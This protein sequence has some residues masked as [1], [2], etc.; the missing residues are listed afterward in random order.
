MTDLRE[1]D[2]IEF[3]TCPRC[4]LSFQ[5]CGGFPK[6]LYIPASKMLKTLNNNGYYWCPKCNRFFQDNDEEI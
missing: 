4:S 2:S 1:I 3:P 6:L 5:H